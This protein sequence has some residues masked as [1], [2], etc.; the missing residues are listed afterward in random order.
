[1]NNNNFLLNIKND[2]SSGL[3]V[4]LVALPLC[5]GIAIASGASPFSGIITGII[6]GIIVGYLSGS[7]V[8][9]SGPAAGLIS[10]VLIAIKDLGF[11]SF[12][13][14]VLLAGIFQLILGFIK[15]GSIANYFP[16]A[17]IEGMLAGIGIIIIMKEIPHAIGYDKEHEGDFFS[18]NLTSIED[19]G[20]FNELI[21]SF[22]FT[23]LG[24][25]FVTVLSILT[26]LAFNNISF[27]KKI[28]LLPGA[29]VVVIV[30]VVVNELYKIINPTLLISGDHLVKLPILNSTN[31]FFN[32]FI[33]PDLASISNLK[34]WITAFVITAVAS[35]ETLLCI[36]AGDKLDPLK[37]YSN[38]NIEL[39]AQGIGNIL[40]GLLGGL[41]M[42]SVIVRTS[43]NI[44]SGA[45]T[46]MSTIFHGILLLLSIVFIPFIINK[47]PMACLA[48]ILI[49]I[50]IKL[51]S[52]KVFVHMWKNGK[53]QFIPFIATVIGVV[54]L[55][56][57]KGVGIG[58]LVTV[59][60]FLSRNMK[61]AYFSKTEDLQ[62]GETILIELKQEVSFLNR[63][64][65]KET[66]ANL[67]ENSKVLISAKNSIY[68]DYDVIV[69]IKEF[70]HFGSKVKN[71][72]VDLEG[73]KDEFKIT[74]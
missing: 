8:S 56:L 35:V 55:D 29:L 3:V 50:G 70:Y 59:F 57:L 2:L 12:L 67:P 14:A 4:Y 31:D 65:I 27:L 53:I 37:R 72:S 26:L 69:L 32:Q 24:I 13:L 41:P 64:S 61:I 6:A 18:Y 22:N 9:V 7:N 23:H 46:K 33:F 25:L 15:A 45:R 16:S 11:E 17:V 36:E 74:N 68:I 60:Y 20:F 1:M 44:N 39:K 47:I 21:H 71:I 42:T 28:K 10:I 48:A 19:K 51:A 34:V 73:F 43:A 62:Q 49:M 38:P 54:S 52:P 40:S 5:L 63:A 66:L 58:L 30:G